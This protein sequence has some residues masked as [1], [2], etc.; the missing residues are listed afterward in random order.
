VLD[1]KDI[2]FIATSIITSSRW[3]GETF[4]AARRAAPQTRPD[5]KAA[6]RPDKQ[7]FVK[8][9]RRLIDELIGLLGEENIILTPRPNN[10]DAPKNRYTN[11]PW[12]KPN[13]NGNGGSYG[14]KGPASP[15]VTRFN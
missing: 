9:S 10:N 5:V 8:R 14:A 3:A 6:I 4:S 15:A 1:R 13:G 2:S 12:T 7:W 11:R